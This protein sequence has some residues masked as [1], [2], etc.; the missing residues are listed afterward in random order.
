MAIV[1]SKIGNVFPFE[2]DEQVALMEWWRLNCR[3]YG[4]DEKLLFAIPNGG[5]RNAVTGA[6][7][8]AEGVQRGVPD[9]LLAVARLNCH[10]LF[11]E[12]KTV[13]GKVSKYQAEMIDTLKSNG[14]AVYVGRS[15]KSVCNVIDNYLRGVFLYPEAGY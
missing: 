9:L 13:K 2:H 4:V 15:W 14:Y 8:T 3:H 12:M 7:L 5:R 10:G 6:R 11:I 1:R